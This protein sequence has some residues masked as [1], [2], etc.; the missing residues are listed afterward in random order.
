MKKLIIITIL[1]MATS[2]VAKDK[3]TQA[4]LDAEK[5]RTAQAVNLYLQSVITPLERRVKA[6]KK[7]IQQNALEIKRLT[8]PKK[9]KKKRVK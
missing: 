5:L 7:Q 8:P 9:E 6:L 2:A 4:D 3:I 1:L